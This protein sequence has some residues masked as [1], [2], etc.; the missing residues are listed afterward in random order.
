MTWGCCS[1][2]H[3]HT[4]SDKDVQVNRRNFSYTRLSPIPEVIYREAEIKAQEQK[5]FYNS[6]R[7]D[8][9]NGV[10][11]L[12]E[13]IFEHW[14]S[15]K[16]VN[17]TVELEKT[18]HD[19]RVHTYTVDVK[20]KDRTVKPK[21]FYDNSAP[22][23]NHLHQRPDYFFFISLE[24][25]KSIDSKDLRR[26]HSAYLL[27]GISYT[28]LDRIGVPFLEDEEDWRNK[29]RFWTDCLNVEMWQLVP[30]A[31]MLEIF[32]GNRKEPTHSAVIN[33]KLILAMKK[34]IANGSL[35]D[36]QLPSPIAI[37]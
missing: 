22:L 17:F 11:C 5:I 25:S 15:K 18:T 6:H 28:E 13:V 4:N 30:N 37:K 23:Y 26:F 10:G 16:D 32:E 29:T 7:K 35:K 2:N 14:L 21:D 36:R 20:T 12:G 27:G 8:E 3:K 19:Y 9:A 34:R 24:R 33:E 1:Q 31:E